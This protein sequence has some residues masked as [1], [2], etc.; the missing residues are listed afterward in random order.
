[1]VARA[2]EA[3]LGAGLGPVVVVT[4]FE[5]ER[6]EGAVTGLAVTTV[7]NPDHAAGMGSSLGRGIAA[8]TDDVAGVVIA[9]GDMPH[10]R[11]ETIRCLVRAFNPVAGPG[12][13]IP[14][15][16]GRRGNPV[17][18]AHRFFPALMVLE[19]D[20][21]GKGVIAA[22]PDDVAEVA[23]E[24]G[25]VHV[26]YDAADNGDYDAGDNAGGGPGTPE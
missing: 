14:V 19:G 3:V 5:A 12:I 21:G 8:L 23:V 24:D 13:C 2:V 25:G 15:F 20:R 1:M 18:F 6:I 16:D 9:L 22:N 10:I 26:D 17:L 11:P 7:H 4:G